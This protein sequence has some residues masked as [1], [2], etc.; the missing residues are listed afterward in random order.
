MSGLEK[1]ILERAGME[2]VQAL[3]ARPP[4]I[5]RLEAWVGQVEG[6]L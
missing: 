3:F 2:A 1:R 6:A 4:T 5:D